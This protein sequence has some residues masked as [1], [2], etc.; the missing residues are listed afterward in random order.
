MANAY[1]RPMRSVGIGTVIVVLGLAASTAFAAPLSNG[2]WL[3]Q[4]NYG[5]GKSRLIRIDVED[6][7]PGPQAAI[8]TLSGSTIAKCS[9]GPKRKVV[10]TYTA[11]KPRIEIVGNSSFSSKWI[12]LVS[13]S[14][15]S[16]KIK[17]KG[18]IDTSRVKGTLWFRATTKLFGKC[19][20]K[21]KFSVKVQATPTRRRFCQPGRTASIQSQLR[22]HSASA[23]SAGRLMVRGLH[24]LGVKTGEPMGNSLPELPGPASVPAYR[25]STV[26][27]PLA[28]ATFPNGMK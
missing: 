24:P 22:P 23:S 7:G 20:V 3:F 16:G 2:N 17:L 4:S 27:R 12:K 21:E 10:I 1:G 8:M 14:G 25:S 18:S 15:F 6:T 11:K 9:K 13:Y 5:G 26:W 28:S 19:S